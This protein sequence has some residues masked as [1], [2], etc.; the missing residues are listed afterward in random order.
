MEHWTCMYV[1]N[2]V[3]LS[4]Y[5]IDSGVDIYTALPGAVGAL[6]D[7][8]HDGAWIDKIF[9]VIAELIKHVELKRVVDVK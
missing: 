3:W 8:L 2:F 5:G 9:L 1:G 4:M 7:P 6:C